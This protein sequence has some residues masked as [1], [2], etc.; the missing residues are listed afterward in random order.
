MQI[1]KRFPDTIT[2]NV[3]R[4]RLAQHGIVAVVPLEVLENVFWDNF[5]MRGARLIVQDEDLMEADAILRSS[6]EVVV[7]ADDA[8]TATRSGALEQ[9][10]GGPSAIGE[11]FRSNVASIQALASIKSVATLIIILFLFGPLLSWLVDLM[12]G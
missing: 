1:V 12:R 7:V 9:E 8:N 11:F 10:V 6:G 5:P 4:M 3:A 2:A